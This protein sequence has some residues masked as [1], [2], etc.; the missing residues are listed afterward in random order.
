[1]IVRDIAASFKHSWAT[2]AAVL[3]WKS[4]SLLKCAVCAPENGKLAIS[5]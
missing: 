3:E 4:G 5:A 2:S 1:M